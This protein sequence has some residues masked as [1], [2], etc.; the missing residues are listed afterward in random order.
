MVYT[1]VRTT[2]IFLL[3]AFFYADYVRDLLALLPRFQAGK[4]EE[5]E[6]I[7]NESETEK[8]EAEKEENEEQEEKVEPEEAQMEEPKD[9]KINPI[10][11]AIYEYLEELDRS[12]CKM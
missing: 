10:R 5:E 12:R 2:L 6:E 8:E 7:E 3:V 4:K 11:L 9:E 1:G